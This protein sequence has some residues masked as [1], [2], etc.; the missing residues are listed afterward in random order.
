[1]TIS[2]NRLVASGVLR[3]YRVSNGVFRNRQVAAR[4]QTALLSVATFFF[5]NRSATL[6]FDGWKMKIRLAFYNG[7][8]HKFLKTLKR[9]Q[10]TMKNCTNHTPIRSIRSLEDRD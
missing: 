9:A 8:Q 5:F 10:K 3:N 7:K 4:D 2:N 6:R 1:M